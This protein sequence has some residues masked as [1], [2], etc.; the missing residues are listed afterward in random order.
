MS[1]PLARL[2]AR[3]GEPV[4]RRRTVRLRLTLLYGGLFLLSGVGLLAITYGLVAGTPPVPVLRVPAT[5]TNAPTP[6]VQGLLL[7][8][9]TRQH[10]AELNQILVRSGIALT[11][12]TVVSIAL[13][14]VMAGR[15][16]RP[17]RIM[18]LTTQRISEEN[19][20]QRLS[21]PGPSDELKDLAD[22]IDR[23]LARLEAAFDSQRNFVANASHELRTPLTLTR[24]LLQMRL[25]EP[26]ATVQ[27]FRSTCEEVL[28][29]GEQ[30]ERLIESLLTLARS[31]RGLDHR[32]P[33]ELAA[34][35]KDI[36]D[37]H[38]PTAATAGVQL[39]V[40]AEPAL[41]SGD[42]GLAERLVSNLVE[43]AIRYNHPG[44][45]VK[46]IVRRWK[47]RAGLTVT[48]TGPLVSAAEVGR[49]L[50]PFQR[51]ARDRVA[52]DGGLGLGLSIVAAIAR[53]H[54]AVLDVHPGEAGGLVVNVD[55]P[56]T[57][58]SAM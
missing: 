44:G 24:A 19:L 57:S 45:C 42:P 39:Y 15:V 6:F 38:Q 43:N 53:T 55:F 9:V 1:G 3:V 30:Q 50:L 47:S 34:L 52:D 13:G 22:T 48:N 27:S 25:R 35:V 58:T 28:T 17:L 5:T 23:L 51:S 29:A 49:L 14:W 40:S 33:F 18:T 12:M 2:A 11:I 21:L 46:I 8:A 10:A 56:L 54:E 7:A 36:Q 41:V 37:T 4:A 31:Q 20:H 26:E 32:E 16:L